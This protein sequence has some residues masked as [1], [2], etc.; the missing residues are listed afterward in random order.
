MPA[1]RLTLTSKATKSFTQARHPRRK[2]RPRRYRRVHHSTGFNNTLLGFNSKSPFPPYKMYKLQYAENH[3]YSV[4]TAGV[5]GN[6]QKWVLND[7]YDVDNTGVGHQPYGFDA[8]SVAYGRYKVIGA[9]V[10]ITVNDPDADGVAF[11]Y[12]I[13]NPSNS[14][15]FINTKT[16]DVIREAQQGGMIMINNSGSQKVTRKFFV[17][18]YKAAGVTKLQ[19]NADPDNYT[20]GVTGS[21]SSKVALLTGIADLRGGSSATCLV[22][23]KITFHA[24][25]YQRKIMAQS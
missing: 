6:Q 2:V 23:T 13:A 20:A 9:T 25:F 12:M 5:I 8:L 10:E 7:C 3:V 16:P 24:I 19:F 4:G 15:D 22:S 18:M 21:P 17:P 11:C 14:T 1:G